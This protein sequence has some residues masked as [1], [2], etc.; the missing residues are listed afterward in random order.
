MIKQKVVGYEHI[1][2]AIN[3]IGYDKILNIIPIHS[4]DGSLIVILYK[5]KFKELYGNNIIRGV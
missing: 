1:A 5:E 4:Y 3:E 2:D